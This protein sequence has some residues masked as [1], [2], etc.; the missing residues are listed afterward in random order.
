MLRTFSPHPP[1]FS[2]ITLPLL[3]VLVFSTTHPLHVFGLLVFAS[4]LVKVAMA[5]MWSW[6]CQPCRIQWLSSP[7]P[8]SYILFTSASLVFTRLCGEG[9]QYRCLLGSWA[10]RQWFQVKPHTYFW[11][12]LK[13]NRGPAL[14]R[15]C[16][17]VSWAILN[18]TV[19][20]RDDGLLPA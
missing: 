17:W 12:L 14:S 8:S 11:W 10:L 19:S 15:A 5:A 7:S 1:L 6:L 16:L 18:F 20:G 9:W 2:L 4:L 3:L 13:E